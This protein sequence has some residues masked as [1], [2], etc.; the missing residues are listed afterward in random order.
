MK[1]DQGIVEQMEADDNWV[2]D[3]FQIPKGVFI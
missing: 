3:C 1:E 2:D